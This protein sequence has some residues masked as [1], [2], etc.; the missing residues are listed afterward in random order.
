[1]IFLNYSRLIVLWAEGPSIPLQEQILKSSRSAA[2]NFVLYK[3]ILTK[4]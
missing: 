3:R 2:L 4:V 1:M